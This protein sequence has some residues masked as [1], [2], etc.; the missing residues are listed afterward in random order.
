[1]ADGTEPGELTLALVGNPNVGKSTL[2][3]AITGGTV[4]TANYPGTTIEVTAATVTMGETMTR[5]LDLP[6]AYGLSGATIADQ[7]LGRR[8]LL[9]DGPDRIVVV[10]DATNLAR[11]LYLV[12]QVLDLGLPTVVALNLMDAAA[13]EGLHTDIPRLAHD[14][15]VPVVATVASR[16][17]GTSQ[18]MDEVLAFEHGTRT[19]RYDRRIER[20]V[21]ALE[22]SL[23]PGTSR[24]DAL[25]LLEGDGDTAEKFPESAAVAE[26]LTA[27]LG[28]EG[29]LPLVV[30]DRHRLAAELAATAQRPRGELPPDRFWK[31]ATHPLGGFILLAAMLVGLVAFLFFV[32]NALAT[33]LTGLWSA[34]VSPMIGAL[35]HALFGTGTLA[36]TL[37]WGFDSG[38]IAA[39]AVGIPFVLTVYFML[40]VLEDSGYLNA[41]AFIA[42]RSMSG[43]GLHG[44]AVI[45][46]FA[47]FGCSVPAIIS[48][49]VLSNPRERTVAS[50]MVALIPCSARTAVIAGAVAR[51][52]GWEAAVWVFVVDLLIVAVTGRVLNQL[53]PGKSSG[54]MME[55]FPFRRPILRHVWRKTWQ[56]FRTFVM[57]AMPIVVIGSLILGALYESGWMWMLTRP[58]SPIIVDWLR[59]PPVAGLALLFAVLRKELALQLLVT[60]AIVRYGTHASDLLRFMTAPQIVTYALVNTLLIPCI[61]TI[62]VLRAELGT[63]RMLAIGGTSICIAMLVGGVAARALPVIM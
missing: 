44:R 12:L 55:V 7:A 52:V 5:V 22:G 32:G 35:V 63:K 24:A 19:P 48:T 58:M 16:G 38:V 51:F 30:A 53:L 10:V 62:A 28:D 27:S 61:A 46:L 18:L 50:M 26:L 41:A 54:L 23:P 39:L 20:A 4:E 33:A 36:R 45:P 21:E 59:L 37:L 43:L 40:A 14:L 8:H 56:R 42:D 47:G 13:R 60:L 34:L 49:R 2:F 17:A 1:V 9:D 31:L 15:R 6:G 57:V 29:G 25:L 3:N 11:N